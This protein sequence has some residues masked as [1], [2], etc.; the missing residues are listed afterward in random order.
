MTAKSARNRLSLLAA[1]VIRCSPIPQPAIPT[2]NNQPSKLAN[3]G[4]NADFIGLLPLPA[5]GRHRRSIGYH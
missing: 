4:Y 5:V 2:A 1:G 3:S